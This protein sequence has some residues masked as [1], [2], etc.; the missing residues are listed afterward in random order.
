MDFREYSRWTRTTAIYKNEKDAIMCC[1]LGLNGELQEFQEKVNEAGEPATSFI[2]KELGDVL[3]YLGQLSFLTNIEPQDLGDED[4]SIM[5]HGSSIIGRLHE[6]FKKIIRDD[7]FII[8][9]EKQERVFMNFSQVYTMV[10]NECLDN[11]WDISDIMQMNMD[12]LNDRLARNVIGGSG[13]AR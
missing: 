12:K 3:W 1:L 4:L 2:K 6:T 5:L 13:D 8:P 11:D 9:S 10:V 7:N